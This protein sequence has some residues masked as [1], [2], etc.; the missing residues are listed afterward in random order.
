[1]E[2]GNL[3]VLVDAKTEYTKQLINILKMN[4]YFSIN[5][6]FLESKNSCIELKQEYMVLNKFQEALSNIPNWNQ[7]VIN[8]EYEK[9][10]DHVSSYI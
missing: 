4:I 8:N 10:I 6:L 1:M 5:K 9:S 7:D 3:T 2:E